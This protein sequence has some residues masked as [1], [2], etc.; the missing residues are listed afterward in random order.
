MRCTT[1]KQQTKV[2]IHTYKSYFASLIYV[3]ILHY[4]IRDSTH[5]RCTT[6]KL[7][8]LHIYTLHADHSIFIQSER[9][10]IYTSGSDDPDISSSEP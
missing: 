1:F 8:Y 4:L 5:P 6:K 7:L 10:H 2:D 9:M 3:G